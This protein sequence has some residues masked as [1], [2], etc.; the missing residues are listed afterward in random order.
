M[1][2]TVLMSRLPGATLHFDG[3]GQV[4]GPIAGGVVLEGPDGDIEDVWYA[5]LGTHNVAEYSTLLFG[6]GLTRAHGFA[7]VNIFG[8]SKLVVE[9]VNGR[10]KCRAAD[11]H[12]LLD[13]VRRELAHFDSWTL[14]WIPRHENR[15]ADALARACLAAGGRSNPATQKPGENR[16]A[17][18]LTLRRS[19]PS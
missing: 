10:W 11:L 6:L 7:S 17:D 18:S 14:S 13:Q 16:P 19:K 1:T 8:D 2:D 9:Q 12:A 5:D 15:R 3:G 4:P